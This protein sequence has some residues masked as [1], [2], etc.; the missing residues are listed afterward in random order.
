MLGI[1]AGQIDIQRLI[2]WHVFKAFHHASL[3]LDELNHINFDW[4]APA[5]AHRQSP[6]EVRAWCADAELAVT[7]EVIEQA[8]ITVIARKEK[9]PRAA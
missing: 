3:D 9:R 1:P 8:G 5:N 7:R 6:E 4:Y 2:Y